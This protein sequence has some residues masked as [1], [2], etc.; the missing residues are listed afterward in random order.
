MGCRR[1][2]RSEVHPDRYRSKRPRRSKSKIDFRWNTFEHRSWQP[3][4][5]C[6]PWHLSRTFANSY[7]HNHAYRHFN[8]YPRA[9]GNSD[10]HANGNNHTNTTTPASIIAG[11]DSGFLQEHFQKH[12]WWIKNHF[13]A[14]RLLSLF[15][16]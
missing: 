9:D 12:L 15:G 4:A 6:I 8:C 2:L 10:P 3:C 16:K 14:N 1:I 13:S 5:F 11:K 7:T